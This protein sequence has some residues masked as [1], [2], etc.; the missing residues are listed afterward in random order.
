MKRTLLK[1][2][3]IKNIEEAELAIKYGASALGLVS[4]MPSGPGVISED[5]IAEISDFIPPG[6][7]SFLLTSKQDV[8][9]I[10]EQQ[11]RCGTNVIQ[12]VDSLPVGSHQTLKSALPGVKIVQV[13]HVQGESSMD[14]AVSISDKV[15]ALLLDS[16]N[17]TSKVK[18]LGGTGRIHDWKISR[19]IVEQSACPVFLAGGLNPGNIKQ[20]LEEVEP[21]GIDVCSGI[22]TKGNLDENKL[23]LFSEIIFNKIH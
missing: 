14:E 19:A 17:Q 20:A 21:F 18:E 22:R 5:K 23:K 11:K 3:C 6:I 8:E 2:C 4:E 9:Q 15:D 10:I 7:S 1:I 16:G 13:V 12:L